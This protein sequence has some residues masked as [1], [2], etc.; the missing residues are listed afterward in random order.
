MVKVKLYLG[1]AGYCLAKEN[2]AMRGGD[3]RSIK[4]YALWGIIDHPEK[5]MILYDTGYSER[6]FDAT[7]SFP[8]KIYAL[9]TKVHL[10][11]DEDVKSQLVN[12]NIDPDDIKHVIITHFHADHVCG[13]KDFKN[14]KFY[15]SRKAL[16]HVLKIPKSIAFTKAILKDLLPEDLRERCI[17]VEDSCEQLNDETFGYKYDLFNDSTVYI[18]DL[19]GH[20]AG[21]I[22]VCVETE[23]QSYFLISDACW[24]KNAYL[25]DQLPNP[26][27]K[28]FFDSWKK[29][30]DTIKKI[31]KFHKLNPKTLIV[32]THCTESTMDLV[33]QKISFN[34]L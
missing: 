16:G 14:A 1:Y 17:V 5:G 31:K 32:P 25:N 8:N 24:L 2:D 11:K 29:Y 6:F 19:P 22:G 10:K 4:F 15:T 12:N 21:Q 18:Y 33:S 9:A 27:V 23:K 34:E 3:K 7:K 30:K 28:L 20:A 26:I 13:L